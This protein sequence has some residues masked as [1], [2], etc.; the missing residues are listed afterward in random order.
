MV[1]GPSPR[2]GGRARERP[3]L[4]LPLLP[5]LLSHPL[6]L[7]FDYFPAVLRTG[8]S[9]TSSHSNVRLCPPDS[10]LPP[11]PQS[12]LE[13]TQSD[14]RFMALPGAAASLESLHSAI[15]AMLSDALLAKVR[16]T[17]RDRAG[18]PRGPA[19]AC[20]PSLHFTHTHT[21]S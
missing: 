21:Y 11:S 16:E 3:L 18:H 20:P 17:G 1:E 2:A 13:S 9:L 19:H 12:L 7:S 6:L 15:T 14:P 10:A 4:L 5:P 8:A